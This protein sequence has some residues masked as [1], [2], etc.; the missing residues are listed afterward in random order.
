MIKNETVPTDIQLKPIFSRPT[1]PLSQYRND[2]YFQC[3][4]WLSYIGYIGAY[5]GYLNDAKYSAL[6]EYKIID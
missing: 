1:S 2:F 5:I 3:L 6:S 4:C